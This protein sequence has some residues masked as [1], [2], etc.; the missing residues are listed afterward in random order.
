MKTRNTRDSGRKMITSRW[1]LK[2]HLLLRLKTTSLSNKKSFLR[3]FSLAGKHRKGLLNFKIVLF[4]KFINKLYQVHKLKGANFWPKP[5]GK[6]WNFSC[7][8]WTSSGAYRENWPTSHYIKTFLV[9]NAKIV[10]KQPQKRS[11]TLNFTI[12]KDST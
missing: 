7:T 10:Y 9:S 6:K 4:K 3:F 1:S 11:Q 8:A 5:L 12:V 2:W